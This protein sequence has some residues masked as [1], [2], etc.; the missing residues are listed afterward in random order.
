LLFFIS[1][2]IKLSCRRN[3]PDKPITQCFLFPK[4]AADLQHCVVTLS[5]MCGRKNT[6]LLPVLCRARRRKAQPNT[7]QDKKVS[8][9]FQSG[10]EKGRKIGIGGVKTD[11]KSFRWTFFL[12]DNEYERKEVKKKIE[13]CVIY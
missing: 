10:S 13:Q 4:Y 2:L 11:F 6:A 8:K 1:L 9:T 5:Q 12:S 7:V 3:K